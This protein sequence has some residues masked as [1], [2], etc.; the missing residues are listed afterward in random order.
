ME[1]RRII[2]VISY[3]GEADL[4]ELRLNVLDGYVDEFII[5]EA[6]LTFSGNKKPLYFDQQRERFSKWMHK[7]KYYVIDENDPELWQMARLSPNTKGAEH[8]KREFVQKESIKKAL[9][10]L[11]DD[12]IVLIG[13]CDEIVNIS[14]IRPIIHNNLPYKVNLQV[15][16]YWLNNHSSEE[17]WGTLVSSYKIIKEECLNHL[18]TNSRKGRKYDPDSGW[19]YINGW[20]FTSMAND[21][22]RKLEDSYTYDS[23]AHPQIMEHL[24]ENIKQNKD[25]LG[26]KFTFTTDES[27]WP[28]Y[29]TI[30]RE[31]YKHLLK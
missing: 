15:Y 12:D 6:F 30:N 16:T 5:C 20:H 28:E 13:D 31:H 11:K 23:Y 26:R 22:R 3:N 24:D 25:F 10:H 29:L 9:V 7:I 19:F 1:K 2:D 14:S 8:W 27:H 17:F 18:R 4:L 21:L